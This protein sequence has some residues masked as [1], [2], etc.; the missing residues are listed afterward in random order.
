MHKRKYFDFKVQTESEVLRGVCFSPERRQKLEDIQTAKSPVKL[1]NYTQNNK[2]GPT[3][4]VIERNTQILTTPDAPFSFAPLKIDIAIQDLRSVTPNRI[5]TV[6]GKLTKLCKAK[7][8]PG[9]TFTKQE[10]LVADTT[11][12]V[13][14]VL[15]ETFVGTCNEGES[16]KFSN[17]VYKQDNYGTYIASTRQLCKVQKIEDIVD[18]VKE[19][20]V[21]LEMKEK[22]AKVIGVSSALKYLSCCACKK[23]IDS[24]NNDMSC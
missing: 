6:K 19:S 2:F 18:A 5:I 8:I 14:I 13:K 17:F 15:W 20:M 7:Q 4:I 9:K 21:D 1:K 11:G 24:E 3:N 12:S 16:Y 10:G 23:K 22:T